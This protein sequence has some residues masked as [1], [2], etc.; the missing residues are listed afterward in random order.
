MFHTIPSAAAR[1]CKA[2]RQVDAPVLV[3][4]DRV[5]QRRKQPPGE[6]PDAAIP[7]KRRQ[8]RIPGFLP[9]NGVALLPKLLCGPLQP[10]ALLFQL[11]LHP[12]VLVP[13]QVPLFPVQVE[14]VQ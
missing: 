8:I 10:F 9:R 1:V 7:E 14:A 6:S 12:A 4:V 3:D 2:E 13:G 5:H 11:R